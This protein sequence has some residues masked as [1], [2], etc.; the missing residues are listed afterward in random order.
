MTN[1]VATDLF[2]DSPFSKVN[3]GSLVVEREEKTVDDS[4]EPLS[5]GQMGVTPQLESVARPKDPTGRKIVRKG[6]IVINSRSDR[7]GASGVSGLEGAVSVVYSVMSP[8]TDALDPRFAG[9]LLK[10]DMFQDTFYLAGVG[11]V[12]DLWTTNFNRM[13]SIRV[14]L[15]PLRIQRAI[16][17]YL[18][19]ETAEIDAM[20]AD[21]DE[22]ETLLI[23]RRRGTVETILLG[24]GT[25]T[26]Q[27]L[28]EDWS[29]T[30]LGTVFSFHNGDRG[31]NYPRPEDISDEGIPFINAGD[32]IN[33][34]VDLEGCKRVSPEKYAQMGGAKLQ[35]GDILF[36]LR[37]SLGKWGLM[38]SDGGSLAS[39]LCALRNERPDLVDV[40]Y[41]A[42]AMST[43]VIS[44]QIWFNESGSAQPNL[45]AE[46]VARFRVPLPPFEEQHRIVD[47]IDRETAEIDAMLSDI[48]ELRDLLAERRAAV[49]AAAVTGQ[50]DIPAAE[51][52]THA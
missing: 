50:I 51:E 45:G 42:H 7:R 28:P 41:I 16:A 30:T 52:T 39:S 31:V 25:T 46:Q 5:V 32:L 49:I 14:P 23:E 17:D 37:G 47:E 4:F 26:L 27:S 43:R 19:R 20:T 36:C 11:I 24:G 22:L 33:G 15:P 34:T 2:A 38:E 48:T 44:L 9:H 29:R 40:R 18:D 13:S 35:R 8:K 6:D 12:D 21:L 1:L 10:S 3:W